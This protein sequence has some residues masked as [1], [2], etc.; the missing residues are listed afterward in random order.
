M[1][2]RMLS[3]VRVSQKF[4]RFTMDEARTLFRTFSI[5]CTSGFMSIASARFT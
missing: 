5:C 4:Q 1:I 2:G 3:A